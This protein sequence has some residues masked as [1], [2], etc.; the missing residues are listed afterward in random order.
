[1]CISVISCTT[2]NDR[3]YLKLWFQVTVSM[4]I[5]QSHSLGVA[6]V[7]GGVVFPVS[8]CVPSLRR[9]SC[10]DALKGMTSSSLICVFFFYFG[11]HFMG[12][13]VFQ[14]EFSFWLTLIWILQI[15]A[16]HIVASYRLMGTV[17]PTVGTWYNLFYIWYQRYNNLFN[18]L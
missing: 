18:I 5:V 2:F 6:A 11:S 9:P 8:A 15:C 14:F 12:Y 10:V 3:K 13:L 17:C 4:N 16:S 1:M 7:N